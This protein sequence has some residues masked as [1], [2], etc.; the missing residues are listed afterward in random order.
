MPSPRRSPE[1]VE[2]EN[3]LIQEL[4]EV[5]LDLKPINRGRFGKAY[6]D[7]K[8]KLNAAEKKADKDAQDAIALADKLLALISEVDHESKRKLAR[9]IMQ[10]RMELD[11]IIAQSADPIEIE[12]EPLIDA[13][14]AI[15]VQ[16]DA[17]VR[18]FIEEY[19]AAP[20]RTS[21]DVS[22]S[23]VSD[24]ASSAEESEYES[25]IDDAQSVEGPAAPGVQWA[26][27]RSSSS[28]SAS[29]SLFANP[30]PANKSS[31]DIIREVILTAVDKQKYKAVNNPSIKVAK[32]KNKKETY[33]ILR[34]NPNPRSNEYD[35]DAPVAMVQIH[36]IPPKGEVAKLWTTTSLP[37]QKDG[38]YAQTT[39]NLLS[40][41]LLMAKDPLL[42]RTSPSIDD[43][44]YQ[45]RY[46]KYAL[47][48]TIRNKEEAR[49]FMLAYA[50]AFYAEMKNKNS[51]VGWE[52]AIGDEMTDVFAKANT[53]LIIKMS[54][55][56]TIKNLQAFF[57]DP[58]ILL[59]PA[60][61]RSAVIP[62]QHLGIVKSYLAVHFGF[63]EVASPGP[64]QHI[65][66]H[67]QSRN[68][69]RRPSGPG[70]RTSPI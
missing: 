20:V 22:E 24:T 13:I 52:N 49:Q 32:F 28:R 2:Q 3:A 14:K 7:R 11:T 42:D 36:E 40:L 55:M 65:G 50:E 30:A 67:S 6:A 61:S 64:N 66:K 48:P 18:K 31:V 25:D 68:Q 57:A 9:E 63:V 43:A 46:E 54:D 8:T 10:R 21:V 38:V 60:Y 23:D 27:S 4:K 62:P 33:P 16:V 41:K 5:N 19:R 26:R 15:E 17:A 47:E 44:A 58:D 45:A 69:T 53:Y 51:N 29:R 34:K 12:D 37:G 35:E 39:Q 56:R 70:H 59:Y 1:R